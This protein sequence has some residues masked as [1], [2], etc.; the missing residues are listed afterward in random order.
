MNVDTPTSPVTNAVD[1]YP[2]QDPYQHHLSALLLEATE[3]Q[4]RLPISECPTGKAIL[5]CRRDLQVKIL[6]AALARRLW[7]LTLGCPESVPR[8]FLLN[9]LC[10]VIMRKKLPFNQEQIE[11]VLTL[12]SEPTAASELGKSI[13][14]QVEWYGTLTESM[15]EALTK[16]RRVLEH[17]R[18]HSLEHR[19]RNLLSRPD[20]A[21]APAEES[22]ERR[23]HWRA[24]LAHARRLPKKLSK[25]WRGKARALLLQIEEEPFANRLLPWILARVARLNK[26]ERKLLEG[27]VCACGELKSPEVADF[28]DQIGTW[29]YQHVQGKG[30][31]A[32]RLANL[33][34]DSLGRMAT[35]DSIRYLVAIES[36]FPYTSTKE[37]A[38]QALAKASEYLNRPFESVRETGIG[39]P[40]PHSRIG[41][42]LVRAHSKILERMLRTGESVSGDSWNRRYLSCRVL[43][44]LAKALLWQSEERTVFGLTTFDAQSEVRLWHPREATSEDVVHWKAFLKTQNIAQPFAQIKRTQFDHLPCQSSPPLRQYQFAALARDRQWHLHLVGRNEGSEVASIKL[45]GIRAEFEIIRAD[46]RGPY[47]RNHTSYE[48]ILLPPRLCGEPPLPRHISE[49]ARD[50]NLFCRVARARPHTP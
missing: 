2:D 20:P 28:L 6:L 39:D 17:Q 21:I 1:G 38:N 33:A 12:A 7:Q 46:P 13:I 10:R 43:R 25:R 22:P 48:V 24:F 11:A 27:V 49:V 37:R 26:E 3:G 42:R 50:W 4:W 30:P 40:D 44:Q 18:D 31:R 16:L 41:K 19:T 23:R 47:H 29:G 34:L 32:L 15:R 45:H 9:E 14:H 8:L 35:T 5:R 36:E